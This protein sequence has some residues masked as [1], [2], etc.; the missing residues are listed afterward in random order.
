MDEDLRQQ[1]ELLQKEN[2]KLSRQLAR[3][4]ATLERNKAVAASLANIDYMQEVERKKQQQYLQLLLENSPDIIFLFDRNGRFAYCTNAFLK[5][6]GIPHFSF[7][8]GHL[9]SE[10]FGTFADRRWVEK[11]SAQLHAAMRENKSLILED[12]LD[13]SGHDPRIYTVHFT[14]M[15]G[16]DGTEGNSLM[17]L[18]DITEIRSAQENAEAARETAERA[19]LAKSEFLANMSHEIRTPLNAV[20]GMTAIAKP[21]DSLKKKDY[22]LQKIEEASKHLLGI[23]NDI[24]DMSKIEANKLEISTSPFHFEKMIQNVINVVNFRV[25]EKKLDFFVRLDPRIPDFLNGDEQRLAQIIANLL[26]NAVKFTPEGGSV[27]LDASL[28][29][30]ESERCVLR[31]AVTDSGIGISAEQQR[32]LFSS[33]QQADTSTSRKFG[34]TGLGLVISKRLTELM[35]GS[36]QVDSELGRGSTFSFTVPLKNCA[37]GQPAPALTVAPGSVRLCAVSASAE[38]S[39]YLRDILRK[40]GLDCDCFAGLEPLGSAPAPYDLCFMDWKTLAPQ[41]LEVLRGLPERGIRQVALVATSLDWNAISEQAAQVGVDTFLIRPIFVSNVLDC[42]NQRLGTGTQEQRK[43][44][45]VEEI[46]LRDYRILLAEDVEINREIV[47]AFLEPTELAIDCAENGV[48]ALRLFSAAPDRYDMIFMDIQMPEMDG[49]E[50]TRRIRALNAQAAGKVP[51]IAM[52]A[53]VFREDVQR[54][55]E[56]GMN[57]HVGKP[58]ELHIVLEK[59]RKYLPPR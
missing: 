4:Q 11:V 2:A 22:C 13:I 21:S 6:A 58:L 17:L 19:N 56:A 10:V 5:T 15:S 32:R 1:V 26:S 51:I 52:T 38:L 37:Q 45:A 43:E 8:N 18:H 3:L 47:L 48:E 34:G 59:L 9:F 55:L 33:F 7:I 30:A 36:I 25:E 46:S 44:A 53:N 28:L 27:S 31:V 39:G 16:G 24:L 57:D 42:L 49:Y 14:P 12:T 35:G 20:I 29:Q 50:A 54:C 23:I 40:F 41:G